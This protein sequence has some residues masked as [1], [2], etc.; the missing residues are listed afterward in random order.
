MEDPSQGRGKVP[1]G[2]PRVHVPRGHQGWPYSAGRLEQV[3]QLPPAT[4]FKLLAE[5]HT[6]SGI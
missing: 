6:I 5:E 4:G 1:T 3:G 2:Q